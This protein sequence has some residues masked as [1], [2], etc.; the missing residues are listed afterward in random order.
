MAYTQD[1][2]S[3]GRKAVWVRVPPCP[4]MDQESIEKILKIKIKPDII[5]LSDYWGRGKDNRVNFGPIA[6][7]VRVLP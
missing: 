3:C 7:L 1:L 4:Y 2:K 5:P 6:Q